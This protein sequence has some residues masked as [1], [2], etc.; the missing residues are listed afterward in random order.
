M[1]TH[2]FVQAAEAQQI[3]FSGTTDPLFTCELKEAS[4]SVCRAQ[5]IPF[6]STTDPLFTCELTEASISVY[7]DTIDPDFE[8]I[9]VKAH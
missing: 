1:Q 2:I 6:S 9:T 3:P 4:I 8:L 5:Q 7:R